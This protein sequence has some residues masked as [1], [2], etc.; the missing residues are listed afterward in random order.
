[1]IERAQERAY[2]AYELDLHVH[3]AHSYDSLVLPRTIVERARQLGLSGV[4][5]TDHGSIRGGLE[6]KEIVGSKNFVVIIGMEVATEIGDILGLFLLSPIKSRRCED[7]VHEIHEQGGIAI[8]PHPYRHHSRLPL[9]LMES[10]DGVEVWNGRDP[11][12]VSHRVRQQLAKPYSLAELGGS[13]AHWSREIG[14]A[15]TIAICPDLSEEHVM[16]AIKARRTVALRCAR[17]G[18]RVETLATKAVKHGR[19]AYNRIP[20]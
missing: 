9:E 7:C 17:S 6:A 13:D 5:I 2:C 14:R 1:M 20:R 8:L 4:A 15:R 16:A 19:R 18:S 12:D 3:S 10:L 11:K